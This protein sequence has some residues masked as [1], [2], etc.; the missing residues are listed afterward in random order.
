M[1]CKIVNNCNKDFS[2]RNKPKWEEHNYLAICFCDGRWFGL[3]KPVKPFYSEQWK[4]KVMTLLREQG[5]F[6]KY[7]DQ[8]DIEDIENMFEVRPGADEVFRCE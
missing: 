1:G 2:D 7:G 8:G 5:D 4:G 6:L 3:H